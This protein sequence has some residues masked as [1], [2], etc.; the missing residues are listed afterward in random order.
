METFTQDFY[1]LYK[2]EWIQAGE[3]TIKKF[4]DKNRSGTILL[5]KDNFPVFLILYKH[6]TEGT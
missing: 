3:Y 4:S 2:Q 6:D 1:W 5:M